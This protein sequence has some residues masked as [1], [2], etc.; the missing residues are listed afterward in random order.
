AQAHD[1]RA[2]PGR[3]AGLRSHR[4]RLLLAAQHGLRGPPGLPGRP[5][6]PVLLPRSRHDLGP[7]RHPGG[8]HPRRACRGPDPP[9]RGAAAPRL[10][11]PQAAGDGCPGDP[12][13]DGGPGRGSARRH[14][15]PQRRGPRRGAPDPLRRGSDRRGSGQGDRPGQ[16]SG[17]GRGHRRRAG[18]AR[19][20]DH[21]GAG[22]AAHRRLDRPGRR[23]ASL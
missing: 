22:P 23:Q 20:A 12:H 13:R 17:R 21:P 18:R 4:V 6:D 5:R 2:D 16:G 15:G 8:A 19:A 1:P 10:L 14:P 3:L 11:R 9:G 7:A